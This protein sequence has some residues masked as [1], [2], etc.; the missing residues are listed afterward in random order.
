MR[1][2][3]KAVRDA[4]LTS[5]A[6]I[7]VAGVALL[8]LKTLIISSEREFDAFLPS[9]ALGI[10]ACFT[11]FA[12]RH[13]Q[14]QLALGVY[15]LAIGGATVILPRLLLTDYGQNDFDVLPLLLGPWYLVV[16]SVLLVISLI[17][18]RHWMKRGKTTLV[19]TLLLAG[20]GALIIL[21]FL[22]ALGSREWRATPYGLDLIVASWIIGTGI[23]LAGSR[24]VTKVNLDANHETF[25][26]E[27]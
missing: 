10:V 12:R 1:I 21:L 27:D 22:V 3:E 26:R 8:S 9:V 20:P 24:F 16:G 14:A 6:A 15:L 2:Q 19:P 18:R 4:A 25:F 13:G 5:A 7:I 17:N 11:L 23:F